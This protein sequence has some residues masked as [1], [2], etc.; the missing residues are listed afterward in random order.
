MQIHFKFQIYL[1]ELSIH[2]L[3][4]ISKGNA[5]FITQTKTDLI[6]GVSY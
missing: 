1:T 2:K 4:K 6:I 5:L 3:A